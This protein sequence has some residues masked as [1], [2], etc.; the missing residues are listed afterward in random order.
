MDDIFWM[1]RVRQEVSLRDKAALKSGQTDAL[2][3]IG[4]EVQKTLNCDNTTRAKSIETVAEESSVSSLGAM[5]D[6]F[7]M[8]R[9]RQ[10]VSLRDKAALKSG[11]TDALGNIGVE[12]QKSAMD[13]IF[14]MDRVRQE[15]S[16]RDKA[17]L[18]SGQT[19]ALG[20]IGVE[21]QK[22]FNSMSTFPR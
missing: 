2:G 18:K 14:W 13:D 12:V 6:I 9:V 3:N 1:D 10:E 17:A 11:Q 20:N 8:D 5:D 16:L 15:V 19:D 7:W 21:V 22:S 4:V